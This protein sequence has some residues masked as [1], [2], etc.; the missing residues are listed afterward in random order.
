M[1]NKFFVIVVIAGL[2]LAGGILLY[3]S[4]E[5]ASVTKVPSASPTV[6]PQQEYTAKGKLFL[7]VPQGNRIYGK[8][9][10]VEVLIVGDSAGEKITGYDV[11]IEIPSDIKVEVHKDQQGYKVV[12]DRKGN[13]LTVSGVK[14]LRNENYLVLQ[15]NVLAR[16]SF[17]VGDTPIN[18]NIYF[19]G[20]GHT[21][22][23]NLITSSARD[24]LYEVKGF[25]VQAG[26][27]ITLG[28]NEAVSIDNNTATV[29]LKEASVPEKNCADCMTTATINVVKDGK[30]EEISFRFGGIAGFMTDTKEVHGYTFSVSDIKSKSVTLHYRK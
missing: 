1:T 6:T 17:T 5:P 23:S 15:N 3:R 21:N 14:D 8:G 4:R 24:I 9:E 28:L 18:L 13:Y 12:S 2:V 27:S 11:M 22:D 29:E 16:L 19:T 20:K 25:T 10:K 26:N 7:A 30:G